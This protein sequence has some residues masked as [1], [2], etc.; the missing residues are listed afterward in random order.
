MLLPGGLAYFMLKTC[1]KYIFHLFVLGNP[2]P[3]VLK[4]YSTVKL[5]Q[6]EN[7]CM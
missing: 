2:E 3:D 6:T 1:K 7:I 5:K 4:L